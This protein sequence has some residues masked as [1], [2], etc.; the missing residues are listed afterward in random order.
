MSEEWVRAWPHASLKI[1]NKTFAKKLKAVPPKSCQ[2][3]EKEKE[4]ERKL[5]SVMRSEAQTQKT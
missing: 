2:G 4:K 3:G 5:Q 1:Y